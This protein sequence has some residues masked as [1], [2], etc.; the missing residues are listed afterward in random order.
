MDSILLC[1]FIIT[2]KDQP[3]RTLH[4]CLLSPDP[5]SLAGASFSLILGLSLSPCII[6]YKEIIQSL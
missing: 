5:N 6:S 1:H 4:Q 2:A 3:Q